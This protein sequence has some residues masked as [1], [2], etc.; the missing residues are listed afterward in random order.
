MRKLVTV[1]KIDEIK[2]H[3]NADKLELAIIGG[4]QVVVKKG[5]FKTDEL[6]VYFEID[7]FLPEKEPFEFLR[8]SCYTKNFD[9]STGFRLKTIRLRKQLS[10]GL[11]LPLNEILEYF[12]QPHIRI[13]PYEGQDLTKFLEV[14][15]YERPIPA[16]LSGKVKG[17]KPLFFPKT[18]EERIQ[19]IELS[20]LKDRFNSLDT[21][22]ITEKL[23]GTSFSCYYNDGDFGVCSRNLELKYDEHNTYW[24]IANKYKLKD[25]LEKFGKN[26]T[27]QGEIIGPGIQKNPYKLSEHELRVFKIW[28]IN[29]GGYISSEAMG[30]LCYHIFNLPI[31]PRLS[32]NIPAFEY[33]STDHEAWL[34]HAEG[35]SRLNNETERE[36]IVIKFDSGFSFKVISNKF[37]ENGG[38]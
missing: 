5:Q 22:T 20:E 7:S 35:K 27:I 18:D 24:Q 21:I 12:K 29:C 2:E 36:G 16:Q 23:D 19:N 33:E 28:D 8:K 31:V 26:I 38:E 9:G 17:S 32:T 34:H 4:W 1:R 13:K 37:L 3:P 6:A 30:Y 15:K 14:T 10:Q 11:L 25:K